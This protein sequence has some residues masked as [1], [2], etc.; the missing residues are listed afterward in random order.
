MRRYKL[1]HAQE[2]ISALHI[3]WRQIMTYYFIS[4]NKLVQ[5]TRLIILSFQIN[6]L[7]FKIVCDIHIVLKHLYYILLGLSATIFY[8]LWFYCGNCNNRKVVKQSEQKPSYIFLL[9]TY[10][11]NFTQ[12]KKNKTV[13]TN[14]AFEFVALRAGDI[15]ACIFISVTSPL[16]FCPHFLLNVHVSI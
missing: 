4:N 2:L 3:K 9:H 11:H 12:K 10:N 15:E 8:F 5:S 6:F 1:V 16:E 7:N 14:P 13:L